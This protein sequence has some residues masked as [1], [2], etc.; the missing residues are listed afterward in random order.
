MFFCFWPKLFLHVT[1]KNCQSAPEMN[2]VCFV[3]EVMQWRMCK[4]LLASC[5][6]NVNKDLL[7]RNPFFFSL[8]LW[9]NLLPLLKCW[10]LAH[11]A[12]VPFCVTCSTSTFDIAIHSLQLRVLR[13]HACGFQILWGTEMSHIEAARASPTSQCIMYRCARDFDNCFVFRF[14]FCFSVFRFSVLQ[15]LYFVWK[16]VAELSSK[17]SSSM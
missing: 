9:D 4:C 11:L 6:Y 5:L 10:D 17:R 1:S 2:I 15:L 8:W 12:S 14:S 7:S 3:L 16:N 13:L